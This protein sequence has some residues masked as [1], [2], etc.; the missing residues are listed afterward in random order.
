MATREEKRQAKIDE[1]I[2][3]INKVKNGEISDV[4]LEKIQEE[5]ALQKKIGRYMH[6]AKG[7]ITKAILGYE[8]NSETAELIGCSYVYYMVHLSRQFHKKMTFDNKFDWEVDHII[9]MSSAKT[10][11]EIQVLSKFTNLRPLWQKDNRK[12][13]SKRLHLI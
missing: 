7:L 11:E 10:I 12:K 5:W 8:N 6:R 13:H 4:E 9:P 1:I 2:D 3:F